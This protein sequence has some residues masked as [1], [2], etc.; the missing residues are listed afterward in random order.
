MRHLSVFKDD[1]FVPRTI[2]PSSGL[3]FLQ[4]PQFLKAR[5][6]FR[7]VPINVVPD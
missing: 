7:F 1:L 4:I 6:V 5:F 3:T 2:R